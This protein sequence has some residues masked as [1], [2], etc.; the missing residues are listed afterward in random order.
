MTS[1]LR[2]YSLIDM[3]T[4]NYIVIADC[5]G[6]VLNEGFSCSSLMELTDFNDAFDP[7]E[8][9]LSAGFLLKD[10]G[11]QITVYDNTTSG[12]VG[13]PHVAIFRQVMVMYG[14]DTEGINTTGIN[15][16]Y[17]CIWLDEALGSAAND[18]GFTLAQV[19][20]LG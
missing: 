2:H 7:V 3:R 20:R 8:E 4:R 1:A 16:F 15:T 19:A 9:S 13:S 17:I 10:L 12:I 6:Y 18:F 5:S 11:R 14:L